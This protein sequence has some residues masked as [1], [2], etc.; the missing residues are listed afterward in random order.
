ML[1]DSNVHM[2]Y[3]LWSESWLNCTNKEFAYQIVTHVIIVIV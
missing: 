1:K 3:H 2:N